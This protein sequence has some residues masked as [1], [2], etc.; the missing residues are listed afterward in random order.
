MV[1]EVAEKRGALTAS[2]MVMSKSSALSIDVQHAH[3]DLRGALA[4][5]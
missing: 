5:R 4:H 3:G 2:T 1:S